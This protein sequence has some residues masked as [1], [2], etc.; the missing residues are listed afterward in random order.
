MYSVVERMGGRIRRVIIS[1]CCDATVSW[2]VALSTA[3]CSPG[4]GHGC[5]Q[6]GSWK[7]FDSTEEACSSVG[8]SF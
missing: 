4:A 3:M 2:D 8:L 6:Y 7:L 1:R 5:A